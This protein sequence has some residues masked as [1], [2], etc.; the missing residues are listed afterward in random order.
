MSLESVRAHLAQIADDIEIIVT[1]EISATVEDAAKAHQVESAQIAKTLSFRIK[2]E[3]LLL[4]T[5]GDMRLDNTKAKAQFGA[6]LSMLKMDEVVALTGHP[7]GGICPFGLKTPLPV[8]CDISLQAFDVVIPAAGA[9]NAALR[10]T[11]TRLAEITA[12]QWVDV[13]QAPRTA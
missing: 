10:I 13:C 11:P 9:I 5:R 4:V 1:Q 7:V 8:Y 6:K 12:A 3:V 2:D